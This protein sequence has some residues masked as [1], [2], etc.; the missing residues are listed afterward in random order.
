M[1]KSKSKEPRSLSAEQVEQ[2]ERLQAQIE[3]LHDE[4]QTLVRKSPND[5]LNTFKLGL[6]NS[7]LQR[8]NALLGSEYRPY[9]EFETFA[10]DRAPSNSDV[11]LILNQYLAALETMRADHIYQ[12]PNSMMWAWR[13]AGLPSEVKTRAP[14]KL[15]KR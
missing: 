14:L 13:I 9:D 3:G 6:V 5:L 8:A 1:P 12:R 11:M 2:F 15:D 7:V 10:D 4:M